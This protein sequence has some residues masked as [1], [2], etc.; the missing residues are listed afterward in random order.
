MNRRLAT[1]KFLAGTY[2]IADMACWSWVLSASKYTDLTE[3]SHVAAWKDRVGVRKA[4]QR[5]RAV[6]AE[7]RKPITDAD[8]KVLFGQRAR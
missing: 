3:F 7:L 4:V 6:A 2:S 1:R 8:R 5:G